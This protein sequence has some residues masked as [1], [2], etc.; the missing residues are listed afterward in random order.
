MPTIGRSGS[1]SHVNVGRALGVW[2][3]LGGVVGWTSVSLVALEHLAVRTLGG[4]AQHSWRC[5]GT[6]VSR[7]SPVEGGIVVTRK[8]YKTQLAGMQALGACIDRSFGPLAQW[9]LPPVVTFRMR[10]RFSLFFFF[11][12]KLEH[13]QQLTIVLRVTRTIGPLHLLLDC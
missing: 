5:R 2:L 6:Q 10:P 9:F 11:F 7:T 13:R 1:G 8:P 4:S 3:S 12:S